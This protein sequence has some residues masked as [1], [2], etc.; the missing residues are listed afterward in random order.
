MKKSSVLLIVQGIYYLLTGL[1]PLLRLNSLPLTG[2]ASPNWLPQPVHLLVLCTGVVLLKGSRDQNIKQGVK[3]LS[4]AAALA[5]LLIDLYFPFS[6]T[7][8]KLFIIDGILQFSCLVLWLC[9]I[10]NFM[11]VKKPVPLHRF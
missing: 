1:W 6:G 7:V 3:V 10:I 5:L 8:S 9:I 11:I 4:I 2:S